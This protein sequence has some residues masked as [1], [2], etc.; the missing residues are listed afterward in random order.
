MQWPETRYI[1]FYVMT[2]KVIAPEI[3]MQ[4]PTPVITQKSRPS[5]CNFLRH[6]GLHE[7]YE[8]NQRVIPPEFFYGCNIFEARVVLP[9]GNDISAIEVTYFS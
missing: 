5:K 1:S 4:W 7:N 9:C 8:M 6:S 3:A 2:A